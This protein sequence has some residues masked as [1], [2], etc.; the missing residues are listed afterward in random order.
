MPR[1]NTYLHPKVVRKIVDKTERLEKFYD[2]GF[3]L[4]SD[5]DLYSS[6]D[7]KHLF[8]NDTFQQMVTKTLSILKLLPSSNRHG[9]NSE[10]WDS[11]TIAV[12]SRS[13]IETRMAFHYFGGFGCDNDEW[14]L[15]YKILM[16]HS[17][18]TDNKMK[19]IWNRTEGID[20]FDGEME[21]LLIKIKSSSYF[22]KIDKSM[23]GKVLNKETIYIYPNHVICANAGIRKRTYSL[24]YKLLSQH[25]H[26]IPRSITHDEEIGFGYL[27]GDEANLIRS[28]LTI[29]IKVLKDSCKNVEE[30]IKKR[31]GLFHPRN[32]DLIAGI[33]GDRANREFDV[34][35][36]SLN[37]IVKSW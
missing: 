29:C 24:A 13:L 36:A 27:S 16:L 15:R 23:L 7:D 28:S 11:S 3:K 19:N 30:I 35:H 6:N 9:G 26:S 18:S 14:S 25:A 10:S 34:N 31:N 4:A 21:S 8:V 37:P 2:L 32:I 5:M 22:G 20:H 1:V 12:I 33:L 17:M